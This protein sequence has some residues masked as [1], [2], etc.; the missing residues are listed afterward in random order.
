MSTTSSSAPS[1]AQKSCE[2]RTMATLAALSYVTRRLLG[3]LPFTKP[4]ALPAIAVAG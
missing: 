2:R 1:E 4:V 3:S